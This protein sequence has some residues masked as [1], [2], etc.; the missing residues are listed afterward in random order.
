MKGGRRKLPMMMKMRRPP[1]PKR[2]NAMRGGM[3][4]Q[5]RRQMMR[6]GLNQKQAQANL[7]M[8]MQKKALNNQRKAQKMVRQFKAAKKRSK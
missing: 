2:Q 3:D 5:K 7:L 8:S 4:A 1:M 6:T